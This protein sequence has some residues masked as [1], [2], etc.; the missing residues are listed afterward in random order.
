MPDQPNAYRPV[1]VLPAARDVDV[2]AAIR[3]GVARARAAE[4]AFH[5]KVLAK[6]RA[7]PGMRAEQAERLVLAEDKGRRVTKSQEEWE[8]LANR[9]PFPGAVFDSGAGRWV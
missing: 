4:E 5:R 3:A 2:V 1:S 8:R 7:N 9:P 6:I